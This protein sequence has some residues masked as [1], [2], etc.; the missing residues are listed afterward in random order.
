[1]YVLHTSQGNHGTW[2]GAEQAQVV[3]VAI[4][5][6]ECGGHIAQA[7][8]YKAPHSGLNSSPRISTS[9]GCKPPPP[10]GAPL[11]APACE[12]V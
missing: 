9:G 5:Q 6:R 10:V 3:Q 8:G 1:M 2:L 7:H 4:C 11:Q 12:H